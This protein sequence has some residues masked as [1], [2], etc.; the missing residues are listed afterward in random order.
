MALQYVPEKETL[1]VRTAPGGRAPLPVVSLN[2]QAVAKVE[3]V[4]GEK[5]EKGPTPPTDPESVPT[6]LLR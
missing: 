1:L 5:E 4:Q 2:Q 6:T 3:P